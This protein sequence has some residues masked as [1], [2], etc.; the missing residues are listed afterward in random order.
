MRDGHY[1]ISKAYTDLIVDYEYVYNG[2]A[3]QLIIG[4][5]LLTGYVTLEG[6][7]KIKEDITGIVKTGI[8]KI[9]KLKIMSTLSMRLGKNAHPVVGTFNALGIPCGERGSQS[10]LEI[11]LLED[12]I[13]SDI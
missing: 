1:H 8:I 4:Q 6:R 7:T 11:Y 12:D 10:V 5:H 13:D 3:Q 9:P 2:K